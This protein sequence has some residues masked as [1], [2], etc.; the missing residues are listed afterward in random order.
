MLAEFFYNLVAPYWPNERHQTDRNLDIVRHIG[1]DTNDLTENMHIDSAEIA[2]AGKV[3]IDLDFQPGQLTIGMHVGAGKMFNRWPI[4]RFG[5]LAQLLKERHDVQIVLFWGPGEQQLSEHFCKYTQFDPIKVPPSTIRKLAASFKNC[6]AIV[7]ND[8]GVMHLAA[9]ADVPLVAIFG[10]TDPA[11]WKPIGDKFVALRGNRKS[12]DAISVE[13]VYS[14]LGKL[15]PQK[16]R[17]SAELSETL[18]QSF[19]KDG[20]KANFDISESVLDRIDQSLKNYS[21]AMKE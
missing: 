21:K 11:E 15:L 10:P 12:T 9:A 8:T 16:I 4:G 3:L 18:D 14:T 13:H 1:V 17:I 19:H 6:D 5:E 2:A 7:C 20:I